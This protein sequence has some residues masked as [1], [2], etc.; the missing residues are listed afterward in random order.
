MPSSGGNHPTHIDGKVVYV[1]L[2]GTWTT[3][4]EGSDAFSRTKVCPLR[5]RRKIMPKGR[6][7]ADVK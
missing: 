1:C 7:N 4:K 2:C 3:A 5:D 6:R